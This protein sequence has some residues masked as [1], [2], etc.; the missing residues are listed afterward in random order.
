[1]TATTNSVGL[2]IVGRI[3][4][5]EFVADALGDNVTVTVD[6]AIDVDVT[7]IATGEVDDEELDEDCD[8]LVELDRDEE[9]DC[10]EGLDRTEVDELEFELF[11]A[12]FWI[13]IAV[14]SKFP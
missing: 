14:S 3:P 1:M 9:L 12:L 4:L 6:V 8:S 2:I 10:D 13:N 11:V 7:W 5:G